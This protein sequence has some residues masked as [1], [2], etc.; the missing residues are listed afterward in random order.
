MK[1]ELS[2]V[3]GPYGIYRKMSR[4]DKI[5]QGWLKDVRD[6][7]SEEKWKELG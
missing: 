3:P 5:C 7:W 2:S 4:V 6:I 1:V